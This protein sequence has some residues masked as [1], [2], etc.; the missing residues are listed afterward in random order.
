MPIRG[1]L[2]TLLAVAAAG[3]AVVATN[4]VLTSGPSDVEKPTAALSADATAYG[5]GGAAPA[6]PAAPVRYDGRTAGD[7]VT[8]QVTMEN[9]QAKAYICS[10][11]KGIESWVRGSA[12]D[13][14]MQLTGDDGASVEATSDGTAVFG[15][16]RSDGKSWPFSAAV[17]KE[18]A[19]AAGTEPAAPAPARQPQQPQP[20]APEPE[21]EPDDSGGSGYGGY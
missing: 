14:R 16:A 8:V 12:T 21:P 9:G 1:P 2:A 10:A 6:A 15:T 20:Q 3:A 19:P 4:V 17:S 18:A 13:G 7:E 11:D 5:T